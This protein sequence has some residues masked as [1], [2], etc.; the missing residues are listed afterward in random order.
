MQR[1]TTACWR[2]NTARGAGDDGF[3]IQSHTAKLTKNLALRN[4]DL[5]IAAVGG[6]IDGSGNQASGNGDPRQCINVVCN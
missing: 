1:T 4:R 3:D 6:V 2:N 5:G